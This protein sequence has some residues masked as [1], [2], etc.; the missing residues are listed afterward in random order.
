M[1]ESETGHDKKYKL[2]II[3]DIAVYTKEVDGYLLELYYLLIWKGYLKK[4]NTFEPSSIIM[5]F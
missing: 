3:R 5:Y 1:L 4:E 2:K